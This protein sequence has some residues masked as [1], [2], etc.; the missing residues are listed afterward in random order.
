TACGELLAEFQRAPDGELATRARQRL[1]EAEPV[2]RRE[3]ATFVKGAHAWS[4]LFA[5]WCLVRRPLLFERLYPLALATATCYAATAHEEEGIVRG[6]RFPFHEIPQVSASAQL[7][8]ALLA[9]GEAVALLAP[10]VAF[11][12]GARRA[13]GGWGDADGPDDVLTTL[14]AFELLLQI[15]PS[16]DPAPTIA[17]LR[18]QQR[19]DGTRSEE[20]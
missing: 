8:S 16:F 1:A 15:D 10:L 14:V 9:V 3:F 5:L 18:A 7:A 19:D 2:M 6:T 11:V 13:T 17:F 4:D 12:V 20:H